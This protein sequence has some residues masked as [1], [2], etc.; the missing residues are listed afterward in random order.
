MDD[1][2]TP[3][4]SAPFTA[5]PLAVQVLI[6]LAALAVGYRLGANARTDGGG[7][8]ERAAIKIDKA[9]EPDPAWVAIDETRKRLEKRLAGFVDES[10]PPPATVF[11]DPKRLSVR[12]RANDFFD[13][14][15][16]VLKPDVMPVLDSVGEELARLGLPIRVEGHTD[17][18]KPGG[19][20][21]FSSNWALSAARA[22]ALADH[23]IEKRFLLPNRFVASG[24]ADTRSI[25]SNG[26]EAGREQNRRIELVVAT[27]P[28]DPL[29]DTVK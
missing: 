16:A 17:N 27:R 20:S 14:G 23:L 7:I 22:A 3:R 18:Q 26:D 4:P 28:E 5:G 10:R 25:A 1:T 2:R 11:K 8:P 29:D 24:L 13:P 12:L 9:S 19:R 6:T 15:E 21:R